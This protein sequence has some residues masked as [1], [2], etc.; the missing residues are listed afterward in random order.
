MPDRQLS[1]KIISWLRSYE[2]RLFFLNLF[3]MNFSFSIFE[4][5]HKNSFT[6]VYAKNRYLS[7][8]NNIAEFGKI[9]NQR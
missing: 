1:S 3:C 2:H 7:L 5:L 4:F 6:F 8:I 9:I